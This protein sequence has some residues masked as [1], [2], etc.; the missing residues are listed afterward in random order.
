MRT[1]ETGNDA[2]TDKELRQ[3]G[4]GEETETVS[5]QRREL[6]R[7][8]VRKEQITRYESLGYPQNAS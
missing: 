4:R 3:K 8:R 5:N 7:E 6:E 2:R 1:K